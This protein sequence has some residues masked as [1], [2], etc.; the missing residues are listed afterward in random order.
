MTTELKGSSTDFLPFNIRRDGGAG[1][2]D[3]PHG[4]R[5]FYLWEQVWQK[6]QMLEIIQNF[7]QF[8]KEEKEGK[9]GKEGKMVRKF[10]FPRYHQLYSVKKLVMHAKYHGT[11]QNYLIQHSEEAERAI[12]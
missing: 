10:I 5:T 6:E 2:P 9:D 11:G 12:L 4:Y 7:L 8:V 3:N 1:N